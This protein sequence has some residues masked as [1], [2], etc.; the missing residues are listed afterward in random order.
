MLMKPGDFDGLDAEYAEDAGLLEATLP[1]YFGHEDPDRQTTLAA[2]R[3]AIAEW[4]SRNRQI[5]LA[6][7]EI[8]RRREHAFAAEGL[9]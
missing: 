4:L 1:P 3:A 9:D 7:R 5:A 6:R 2:Q 8:R